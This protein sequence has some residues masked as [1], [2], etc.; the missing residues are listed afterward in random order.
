METPKCPEDMRCTAMALAAA[1]MALAL[2]ACAGAYVAGD[3]GAHRNS[4][5]L[6]LETGTS[7]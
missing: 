1:L 7:K 2:S 5:H 3:V 4:D 6:E